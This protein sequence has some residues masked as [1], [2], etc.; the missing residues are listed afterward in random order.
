MTTKAKPSNPKD[1]IGS[2]KL[3]LHLFPSTAIVYGSLGLLD[4]ALKYGRSN[5]RAVGVKASIYQDA[6]MRHLMAW[7]EG[8]DCDPDS[9]LH[10]LCH[11][12]ASLAI[13]IEALEAGNLTDDRMFPTNYRDMMDRLTPEVERIKLLHAKKNPRHYTIEDQG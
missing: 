1:L 10:H 3:P 5:F 4:G 9:G 11:A 12:I 7:F 2:S 6:T 8:E 13:L